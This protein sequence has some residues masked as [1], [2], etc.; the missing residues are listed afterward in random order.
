MNDSLGKIIGIEGN[1]VTVKIDYSN[2]LNLGN[3][4]NIHTIFSDGK[5]VLVGEIIKVD[6]ELLKIA[7]VGAGKLID[8]L[9][10]LLSLGR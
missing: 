9:R 5:N 6:L 3:L 10:I 2:I 7:I 1:I 4:M 8:G